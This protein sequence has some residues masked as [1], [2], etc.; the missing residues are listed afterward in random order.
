MSYFAPFGTP[1][2]LYV[3]SYADEEWGTI[4]AL[5]RTDN[6]QFTPSKL[7]FAL[8]APSITSIWVWGICGEDLGRYAFVFSSRNGWL[9]TPGG[10]SSR[11]G[12]SVGVVDTLANTFPAGGGR[13]D[14]TFS[15]ASDNVGRVLFAGKTGIQTEWHISYRI[16]RMFPIAT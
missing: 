14:I 16:V 4:Q 10:V 3:N 15:D 5:I 6:A 2:N 8:A 7:E 1:G 9:R 12:T 13:P 11:L